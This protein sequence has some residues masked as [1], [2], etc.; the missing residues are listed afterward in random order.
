MHY[1]NQLKP[2]IQEVP[3]FK[4]SS[5][6]T[7][8]KLKQNYIYLNCKK[9]YQRLIKQ[10]NITRNLVKIECEALQDLTN[11]KSLVIKP[12]DKCSVR[13]IWDNVDYLKDYKYHL[14][15]NTGYGEVTGDPL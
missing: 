14:N 6:W 11:D 4:I 1:L 8:I 7:S 15:Y 2:L 5:N 3:A 10:I 9:K 12:V 13:V